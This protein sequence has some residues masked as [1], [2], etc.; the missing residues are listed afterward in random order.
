MTDVNRVK[1]SIVALAILMV[2]VLSVITLRQAGN[3]VLNSATGADPTSIF[4]DTPPAPADVLNSLVWL[5]DA[6]DGRV[7]EP[8][9][10][11]AISDAYARAL[12]AVD[13]A[14]RG[15]E[16]APVSDY[17]SGPALDAVES[18]VASNRAAD[19]ATLYVEQ[20]LRLEF[21]SDDGSVVS[22]SVP[23]AETV[24]VIDLDDRRR[25]VVA[26]EEQWRFA[27]LLEDG[28]WRVQQIETL[29]STRIVPEPVPQTLDRRIDGVNALSLQGGDVT[30][31]TF[32]G[33]AAA[34]G[35]EQVA[36]LGLDSVRVFVG[37]PE[38]GQIDVDAIST[39]LDLAA[40]RKIGVVMTLFDG[41]ADHSVDTWR[42]DANY[43]DD[44]VA[45][46]AAHPALV[47]WDLKNEPDLDDERSGG[48]AVVDAWIE[49]TSALVRRLDASTPITVGWSSADQARRALGAIDIVSFHHFGDAARL[50]RS[51]SEL[52]GTVGGRGIVVSEYGRPEWLGRVRGSQPAA[53]A[54]A[55]AD[56]R[57]VL[58]EQDVSGMVWQ[59]QDV[60]L[61]AGAG[62]PAE[63]TY[64]LLRID[65]TERPTAEVIRSGANAVPS[66]AIV[67]RLRGWLPLAIVAGFGLGVIV[68]LGES[69]RRRWRRDEP[70]DVPAGTD[71][72]PGAS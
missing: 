6:N 52:D 51:L 11:K 3:A 61:A 1:R 31:Q 37:G 47:M 65:G 18:M 40:E 41:S 62:S 17:F 45:A 33:V 69:I 55:V 29:E 21:Y 30:W 12:A 46:L 35:L 48:A 70:D 5:P 9:T 10:R 39:F 15:D 19:T 24:R 43:L 28:N 22:L 49:R 50:R 34:D 27:M 63:Q 2:A 54:R 4:N 8:A 14:G 44:V 36:D 59:L 60:T 64:G 71:D 38:F 13:R 42:D 16:A 56:L 68:L 53:Q 23:A 72:Q 32:D 25:T 7:M 57:D 58:D 67:E 20:L 26:S 66:P